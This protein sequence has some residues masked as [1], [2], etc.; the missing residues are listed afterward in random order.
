MNIG[1]ALLVVGAGMAS[2]TAAQRAPELARRLPAPSLAAVIKQLMD[3]IAGTAAYFAG[4]FINRLLARA[5]SGVIFAT[6]VTAAAFLFVQTARYAKS[7]GLSSWFV[8]ALAMI[9]RRSTSS[10][11]TVK[12]YQWLPYSPT[13]SPPPSQENSSHRLTATGAAIATPRSLRPQPP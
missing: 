11:V 3:S 4:P 2:P 9:L 12:P 1:V 7:D 8:V 5:R 6:I 10:T 13:A